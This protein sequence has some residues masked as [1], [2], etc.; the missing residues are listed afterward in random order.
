MNEKYSLEWWKKEYDIDIGT[1]DECKEKIYKIAKEKNLSIK[2][3]V[4]YYMFE[5]IDYMFDKILLKGIT[6][7][8][9]TK[10]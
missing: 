5:F 3:A 7:N 4:Y 1:E 8:N 2:Q 9:E 10:D 6:C